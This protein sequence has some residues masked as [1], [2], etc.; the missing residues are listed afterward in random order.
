MLP[1]ADTTNANP[2]AVSRF[3]TL[4][5]AVG[6]ARVAR[7]KRRI[8]NN[9]PL[10]SVVVVA[11]KKA[12]V[13]ALEYL[14]SYFLAEVNA[15]DVELSTEWEKLC[16]LKV[17][18]NWKDLGKRLGKQMKDVAK[19]IND[20]KFEEI[21][22][23]MKNGEMNVCGFKLTSDDV[24]VKREFAG[25]SK[26]FEACVSDDGSLLVAI[27]TTC[28]EDLFCEL[29]SRSI[30]AAIQKLRKS[31][32]LVVT[33][34]VEMFYEVTDV[35]PQEATLAYSKISEA[36]N[37]HKD[38]VLKRLKQIPKPSS[39]RSRFAVKVA[40]ESL[41][42]MDICKGKFVVYLARPM[43]KCDREALVGLAGNQ[44]LLGDLLEM[45]LST[46]D[47]Q[48]VSQQSSVDVYLD[49]VAYKLERGRHFNV[50]VCDMNL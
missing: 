1:Q 41:T 32:G 27:D 8:R 38:T 44:V 4:Q 39:E 12:D 40:S 29:R 25:D 10:K 20:L 16:A 26:R 37:I 21:V 22:A 47:Y 45:A 11:S 36:L 13:E 14:K 33:D 23:F 19:A 34:K 46:M 28:D 7:E 49:G 35:A 17:Q 30:V 31:A 48:A 42:E 3:K 15:W 18:P 24:L 43:L 9:L 6:L 50:S 5:V 2:T